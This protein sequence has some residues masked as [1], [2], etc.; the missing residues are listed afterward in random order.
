M[1][2]SK[3]RLKLDFIIL[4]Y[5]LKERKYS[6]EISKDFSVDFFD[7][8]VQVFYGT[9][10][11]YFLD[12]QVGE[13]L[14]LS[15]L[16]DVCRQS[17]LDSMTD[18]F[19]KI[20]Q[21]ATSLKLGGKELSD[22]DFKYYMKS[23]KNRKNIDMIRNRYE[24]MIEL[25][26]DEPR[27]PESLNDLVKATMGDINSLNQFQ[28]FDEGTVGSDAQM[29]LNEYKQL[30]LDPS[31]FKGVTIGFPSLDNLT[32][33]FQKGELSVICGM[34]GS[35]KSLLMMNWGI[36]AWLGGN[37]PLSSEILPTGKNILYFSLEMP[38]SNKGEMTQGAYFNKRV[39]C[40]TSELEFSEI[41]N[42]TLSEHDEEHLKKTCDFIDK[43]EKENN[44]FYIVDIPS[45]ARCE[46]IES[47][48]V[49]ISEQYDFD[50]VIIDYMGIMA[51]SGNVSDNEAQNAIAMGLHE[52]ARTYNVPVL[53]AVQLNR[54]Q[55]GKGQSLNNQSYNNTRLSRSA[56]IGH[57]ANNVFM[58]ATRDE[59]ELKEDMILHITKFR[60]GQK[61]R[62]VFTKRYNKMRVY[63]GTPLNSS[64][65]ELDIFEG[66]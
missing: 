58:I 30:K 57:H 47:K 42:G 64:D 21:A 41:R 4:N 31:P 12:P 56:G 9:L 60:D 62:L 18:D 37:S 54:P 23:M 2:T 32:N 14:S 44:T 19:S 33:G 63:D 11:K 15:A 38:R 16:K 48:Y 43:Y 1:E 5:F 59:E 40:A 46:D 24:E 20:Y 53:T 6:L 66:V 29:M 50:L 25:M 34:E 27:S 65:P 7:S 35:G 17:N 22:N 13:V 51:A 39:M 3:D 45:G 61:G 52:F 49:E 28:V 36:N 26:K 8:K 55:G 10:L